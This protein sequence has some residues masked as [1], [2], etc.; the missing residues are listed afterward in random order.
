MDEILTSQG[1][2]I[3][4]SAAQ[5][6]RPVNNQARLFPNVKRP[7]RQA[8]KHHH[9]CQQSSRCHFAHYFSQCPYLP[10]SDKVISYLKPILFDVEDVE[11]ESEQVCDSPVSDNKPA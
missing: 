2:E 8:F 9:L 6:S 11:Q 5:S 7:T 1:A 4:E 10:K 3:I